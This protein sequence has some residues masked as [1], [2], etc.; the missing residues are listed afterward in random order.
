LREITPA[1]TNVLDGAYTVI[2]YAVEGAGEL[3]ALQAGDVVES[4]REVE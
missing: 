3:G 1:G 2:G 4:V